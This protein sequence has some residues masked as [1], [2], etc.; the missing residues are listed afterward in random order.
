MFLPFKDIIM[1]DIRPT[2]VF[3]INLF[4]I[5]STTKQILQICVGHCGSVDTQKNQTWLCSQDTTQSDRT[6]Y[7]LSHD[8]IVRNN[9]PTVT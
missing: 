1:E 3:I 6:L 2:S 5:N 8:S 4:M 9:M 7:V